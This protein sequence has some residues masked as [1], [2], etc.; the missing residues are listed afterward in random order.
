MPVSDSPYKLQVKIGPAEF[1]AEGPEATV[2]EAYQ[3]FLDAIKTEPNRFVASKAFTGIASTLAGMAGV[4]AS[5]TS[6]TPLPLKMSY[7]LL[8]I[9]KE[10]GDT[11]SLRHLPPTPNKIADAAIILLYGY[12]Q[13]KGLEDV[14][15]MRLNESLRRS[16]LNLSRLD[17]EIGVNQSLFRKGGQKNGARYSLNN[18]G[19]QQAERWLAE[20]E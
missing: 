15:V 17:R 14:P 1:S 12:K 3:A 5:V 20:W 4:S 13:M 6:D 19:V 16:G 8:G 11:L 18:L 10:D 9:F 2:K 7:E